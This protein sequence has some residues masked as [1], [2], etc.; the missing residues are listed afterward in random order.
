MMLPLL[1]IMA[2]DI[3]SLRI[4]ISDIDNIDMGSLTH[5]LT[6]RN[7]HFNHETRYLW[8]FNRGWHDTP[9]NLARV[10]FNTILESELQVK[11]NFTK[12]TC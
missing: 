10:D 7:G 12:L 6:S 1:P 3:F 4:L 2:S 5:S 11:L 8:V 9:T